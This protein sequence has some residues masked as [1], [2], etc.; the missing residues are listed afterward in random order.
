VEVLAIV[1]LGESL[2]VIGRVFHH[3]AVPAGNDFDA[4]EVNQNRQGQSCIFASWQLCVK[5][6]MLF[7]PPAIL[8]LRKFS[9]SI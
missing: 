2:K 1:P 9:L 7:V 5:L 3:Q 8:G 4:L 6:N